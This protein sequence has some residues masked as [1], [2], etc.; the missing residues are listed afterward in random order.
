MKL[1]WLG[2]AA[3]ALITTWLGGQYAGDLTNQSTHQDP[4]THQEKHNW[5]P[6]LIT[7]A[8]AADGPTVQTNGFWRGAAIVVGIGKDQSRYRVV[9]GS[10][11]N[12]VQATEMLEK[13]HKAVPDVNVFTADPKPN[14][15]FYGVIV[16]DP[17]PFPDAEKLRDEISDK[18]NVK[19]AYL[20]RYPN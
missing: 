9:V 11:P 16:G 8:Y 10:Y 3:P 2:V 4:V 1:L 13:I 15:D 6:S 18:L 20:S 14:N 12:R 17:L 19:D 7:N 5:I